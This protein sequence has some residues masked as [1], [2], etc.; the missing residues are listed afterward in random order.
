MKK[1]FIVA[2]TLDKVDMIADSSLCKGVQAGIEGAWGPNAEVQS[3]EVFPFDGHVRYDYMDILSEVENVFQNEEFTKEQMVAIA[4]HAA[5][6][7]M[8]DSDPRN[9]AI[10]EAATKLYPEVGVE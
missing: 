3:V 4:K 6:K 8:N 10:F 2:M 5:D 7:L 9:N 1:T